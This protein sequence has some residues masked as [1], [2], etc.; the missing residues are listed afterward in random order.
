MTLNPIASKYVHPGVLVPYSN[1]PTSRTHL[2]ESWRHGL[3]SKTCR[4]ISLRQTRYRVGLLY[5]PTQLSLV[6]FH[7]FPSFLMPRSHIS[8]GHVFFRWVSAAAAQRTWQAVLWTPWIHQGRPD[9]LGVAPWIENH[10]KW[11]YVGKK[12]DTGKRIV[13]G[14]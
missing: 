4:L 2:H 7:V 13:T 6:V 8:G 1:D 12:Q 5:I 3:C 10:Q 9:Y 11:G 14:G